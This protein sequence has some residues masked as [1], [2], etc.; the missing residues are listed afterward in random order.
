M[1]TWNELFQQKE[2]QWQLPHELV[3]ELA[4]KIQAKLSPTCLDLGCGVGRH[5]VY[6]EQKGWTAYGMD[7]APNGLNYARQWLAHENLTARLVRADMTTLPFASNRFDALASTYV[8]YHNPLVLMR[9]TLT[10]ILRVL[11]PSGWTVLTFTTTRSGRYGLGVEIEPGTFAP[12]RGADAGVPHHFS[13]LSELAEDL[14]HF[15]VHRIQLDEKIQ[16]GLLSSH[17]LV[18]AQKPE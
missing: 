11:K 4:G 7:L 13:T 6:L 15:I 12:D 5:L 17:W 2:Y 18:L 10:E 14:D 1:P 16:D 3:I 8:I 9:R